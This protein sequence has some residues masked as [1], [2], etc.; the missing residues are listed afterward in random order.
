MKMTTSTGLIPDHAHSHL[1]L[2]LT[3][4]R[5]GKLE[6]AERAF[7]RAA[8][9]VDDDAEVLRE[10]DKFLIFLERFVDAEKYL[11]LAV[12]ADSYDNLH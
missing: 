6:K 8:E 5:L 7:Y 1:Y 9:L 4:G 11:K 12:E 3:L 10:Y 2:D